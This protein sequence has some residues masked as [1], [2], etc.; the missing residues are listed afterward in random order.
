MPLWV[1]GLDEHYGA[2]ATAAPHHLARQVF[3]AQ[4]LPLGLGMLGRRFAGGP[5]AWLEP[6]LRKLGGVLL[7]VLL[8]L[9]VL[10]IWHVVAGAGLRASLVIVTATLLAIAAGHALGGP[11]PA[12]RTAVGISSAARNPGLALTVATLNAAPP[13]ITATILAYIVIAALTLIPYVGWR[14]RAANVAQG[15]A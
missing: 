10:D 4:L 9:A 15:G 12:T 1:A 11:D 7:V 3:M 13:A 8:V 6:R 2:S 5:A 14:K